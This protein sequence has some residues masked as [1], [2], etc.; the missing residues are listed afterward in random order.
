MT[1]PVRTYNERKATQ[2]ELNRERDLLEGNWE[3]QA[4]T[5]DGEASPP[6]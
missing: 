2:S 6:T 4:I 1:S 5:D 3:I